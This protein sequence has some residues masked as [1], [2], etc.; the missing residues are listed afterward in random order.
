MVDGAAGLVLSICPNISMVDLKQMIMNSSRDRGLYRNV[1]NVGELV[2]IAK[3]DCR[4]ELLLQDVNGNPVSNADVRIS[5][6]SQARR[7]LFTNI[8]L[9][10]AADE[11]E[12]YYRIRSD[13]EGRV[14]C[15][16]PEGYYSITADHMGIRGGNY[17]IGDM[18]NRGIWRNGLESGETTI[19]MT[20]KTYAN[21]NNTQENVFQI[22][23][24]DGNYVD[25]AT[26][27]LY[28]GWGDVNQAGFVQEVIGDDFYYAWGRAVI[29]LP[30]GA[31][32]ARISK[33]GYDT[34]FKEIVI[35]DKM[36]H[37]II[38]PNKQ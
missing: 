6:M 33:E 23:G 7:Y 10:A 11:Q 2:H 3:A 37:I 9:Y 20:L 36:H 8:L 14:I 32:I 18:D 16:L 19:I 35:D 34:V 38:R 27:R 24:S 17:S 29:D 22:I 28:Q 21:I 31:Y 1:L 15:Y 25:G 12:E 26:I 30:A 5:G 4:L 13:S